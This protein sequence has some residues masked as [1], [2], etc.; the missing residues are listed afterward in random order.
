MMP[1]PPQ[2]YYPNPRVVLIA[3]LK[4]EKINLLFNKWN[5]KNIILHL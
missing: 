1:P 3:M 2:L 4:D 5:R